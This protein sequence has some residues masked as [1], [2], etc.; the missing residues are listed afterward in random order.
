MDIAYVLAGL[1]I[2]TI[3]GLTGVGGGSLMTPFLIY[4]G[5]PP[6]TAVG[7][8]LI[9]ASITKTSAVWV[10]HRA[11]NVKWHIVRRLAIGSI[12]AA[13][14]CLLLLEW[15]DVDTER[16]EAVITTVLGVSLMLSALM[17]LFGGALQRGSLAEHAAVFKKLHT[18]WGRPVTISA[19]VIIGVLVSLSSVGAGALGGAVLVTLYPRMPAKAIVAIDLAHAVL[20]TTTAGIGHLLHGS[21]DFILLISLLLGSL[22]GVAI[23][24]RLGTHMPDHILRRILGAL[25]LVLGITFAF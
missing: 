14:A 25:L 20:L 17:L 8:D 10:H 23:G 18:G 1:V 12:P 9:Y 13:I 15:L 16:Q 6:I 24:T 21:V 7:T 3:V 2:G 5:V 22:P 4:Y 19:G 11:R